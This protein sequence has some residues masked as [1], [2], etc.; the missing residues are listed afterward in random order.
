M[1]E[2]KLDQQ[3]H[4]LLALLKQEKEE[5]LEQ[6]LL[7]TQDISLADRKTKGVCWYPVVTGKTGFDAGE[8]L[9]IKIERPDSHTESHQFQSGKAI[10]FFSNSGANTEQKTFVTGVVNYVKRNEMSITINGNEFPEWIDDGK[11]GVQLLFDEKTYKV[12]EKTINTLI[13]TKFKQHIEFRNILIGNA[14]PHFHNNFQ[15]SLPQLNTQQNKALNL[16]ANAESIAVIHGPPGTGKTTTLI[17]T[18]LH[19]LKHEKQILVCAPSNAAVDLLAR[20]FSKEGTNTLRIGHP[21]RVDSTLL[22]L[23]L[24]AKITKHENYKEL[25]A[26]RKRTEEYYKQA[27]KHKRNFGHAQRQARRELYA[28]ARKSRD[29]A[30]QLS[31]Y[32]TTDIINK[33]E[34]IVCTLTGADSRHLAGRDFK[35]IFIDEAAQVL[36]PAS[37]IPILKAQRVIFAGDHHQLPPTVKSFKAA[38]AGLEITLFEKVIQKHKSASIML[39]EQYRMNEKIMTF[40]SHFFYQNRLKANIIAAERLVFPN[41]L[42]LEFIDTAGCGFFEQQDG[43][44]KSTANQEEVVLLYTHLSKYIEQIETEDNFEEIENIGIISPYRAQ[45]KLLQNSFADSISFSAKAVELLD[46]KIAV[47]TIDSFQGQERDIIYISLVRCN[48]EG[49]I[50]F[51]SDTRR[52]NVAMTRAKKKLVVIGDSATISSD[53]FYA[54]FLDYVNEIGAYRSAFEFIY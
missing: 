44:T 9:I 13:D 20:K 23:T 4:Q 19:I 10:S 43:E 28:A 8:R 39:K 15:I 47:N 18:G 6:Y 30:K 27:K 54:A 7:Q 16:A 37:W 34:I 1:P 53:S 41:D 36:E 24:D 12:M 52:M 21:A 31:Y 51:L 46:G 17:Q 40:S 22:S 5:D 26:T 25:R 42:P 35:T 48:E 14:T 3:L 33:A 11:L 50:G 45:V 2:N 49:K 38:K 29:D 32:I